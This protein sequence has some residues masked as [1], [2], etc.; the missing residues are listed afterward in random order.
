MSSANHLIEL[1][2]IKQSAYAEQETF[3]L[4]I[5]THNDHPSQPPSNKLDDNLHLCQI[6]DQQTQ[7]WIIMTK[8][9]NVKVSIWWDLAIDF[10]I[11]TPTRLSLITV[12]IEQ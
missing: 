9:K 5:F 11:K 8:T 12:P 6:M 4:C 3:I 1:N 7:F 2:L 10:K